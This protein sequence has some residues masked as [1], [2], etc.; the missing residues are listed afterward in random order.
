MAVNQ[1]PANSLLRVAGATSYMLFSVTSLVLNAL[2]ATIFIKDRKQLAKS[3][4]YSLTW[5]LIAGDV[6][7][8]TMQLVIAVPITYSGSPIYGTGAFMHAIAAFDT[9]AYTTTMFFTLLMSI[10][11]VTVFLFATVNYVLFNAA[12]CYRFVCSYDLN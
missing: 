12:A 2:L 11:R 10:N 5:P 1:E 4:F 8:Q 3:S 9:F 7:T 6:L